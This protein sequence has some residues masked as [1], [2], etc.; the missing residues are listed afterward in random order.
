MAGVP[1]T[2]S[3]PYL[4]SYW[5]TSLTA[6]HKNVK[7]YRKLWIKKGRPRGKD[8]TSFIGYKN[9][10]TEFRK[11]QRRAVYDEETKDL[12]QLE[13]EY[14]VDKSKFYGKI[15]SRIKNKSVGKNVLEVEGKLI[16]DEDELLTVVCTVSFRRSLYN[17]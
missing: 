9:A 17:V 6:L 10:K 16:A 4:K 2:K 1:A 5:N 13:N 15:S 3:R 7:Y 11:A 12:K 14:D 8:Y